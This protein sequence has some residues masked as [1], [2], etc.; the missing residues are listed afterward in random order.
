LPPGLL[1]RLPGLLAEGVGAG[2]RVAK[3]TVKPRHSIITWMT[4]SSTGVV[5]A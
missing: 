3:V 4:R 5:A 1:D 2:R